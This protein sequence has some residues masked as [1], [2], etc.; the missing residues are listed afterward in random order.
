MLPQEKPE[1]SKENLHF[2]GDWKEKTLRFAKSFSMPGKFKKRGLS[3]QPGPKKLCDS[4]EVSVE[5]G[6]CF[7]SPSQQLGAP[8]TAERKIRKFFSILNPSIEKI[9][10]WGRPQLLR[11]TPE[12]GAPLNDGALRFQFWSFV[13]GLHSSEVDPQTRSFPSELVGVLLLQVEPSGHIMERCPRSCSWPGRVFKVP[14]PRHATFS[15]VAPQSYSQGQKAA[16]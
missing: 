16:G 5:R 2:N 10:G 4:Q 13:Q 15:A 12:T 9:S 11:G 7:G 8:P 1:K 6:S 14:I 3:T